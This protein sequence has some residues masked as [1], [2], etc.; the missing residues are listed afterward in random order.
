VNWLFPPFSAPQNSLERR[1]LNYAALFLTFFALILTLSPA[2]RLH[3]WQVDYRWVHWIG[4]AAWITSFSLA[5]RAV[6]RWSEEHD[7]YVLPLCGLLTGWGL[8]TIFRLDTMLGYRQTLWLVAGML[9]LIFAIHRSHWLGW[10]RRY[11][12][13]WLTTGLLLTA[14]T[15][16]FGTHPVG[17]GPRLWLGCCG[18]FFQPSEP[19]KVLLIL[20][21]AAYLADRIPLQF[22][23][24]AL[25]A[26]TLVMTGVAALLLIVQRDLGA[27]SLIIAIYTLVIFLASGRRR[28]LLFSSIFLAISAVVGLLVFDVIRL[29]VEAWLNPWNDTA[30]RSFQIVQSLISF[31]AG[32]L[33]GSGPGL[34]SPGLVPVAHSDFIAAAIS[35]E[36]GLAGMVGLLAVIALL[37]FR[38]L[39]IALRAR[40]SFYRFLAAGI[41][42]YIAVQSILIIGGNIRL[43]PLTGVTLPFVSYGG[44]S[45]A[46][47]LIAILFILW[48]S[49]SNGSLPLPVVRPLPYVWVASLFLAGF[50]SLAL[51]SGWWA[52]V[53]ADDLLARPD[54]VRWMVNARFVPR[55]DL[56]DRRNQVIATTVGSRGDLQRQ[57]LYPPLGNTVG[58]VNPR[59]GRAGLEASF[60][61]HLS[62]LR[63]NPASTIWLA[64]WIY[65]Q[66]PTGLR[67]RL[68][69]DIEQQRN[70]D[71]LLE[72]RTG[73]AVLLN[74]NTGEVLIMASHPYFDP[75]QLEQRYEEWLADPSAPLVNRATQGQYP[76][77]NSLGPFLYT[78]AKTRDG[79]PLFPARLSYTIND[80]IFSCA[81]PPR[82]PLTWET[83]IEAGCPAPLVELGRVIGAVQMR[84]LFRNL[85]FYSAPDANLPVSPPA[86]DEPIVSTRLA[87]LGHGGLRVSPLQMALAAAALT[88][89][90][91]RPAPRLAI[92]V[93]TPNQGWIILPAQPAMQ[94]LPAEE[95]NQAVSS[96][97]SADIPV[98]ET[99]AA[100]TEGQ[101][102]VSWYVAGTLPN[103]GGTPLALAVLIEEDNAQ[104]VQAIGRTIL[105]NALQPVNP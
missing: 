11:K 99:V 48:I 37:T 45:L 3:S 38:C 64:E 75:N 8:L 18:F 25:L 91:I 59:F 105:R 92:S 98:W 49:G 4:W 71:Q 81:R 72:G 60:D 95:T 63:A 82:T 9:V 10:L 35:E 86:L 23:L 14:L 2:V 87:S 84:D 15:F 65:S 102:S 31:A 97:S 29:R 12:Y 104:Q 57:L 5:Y 54:N 100:H 94:A 7:P 6:N 62:G 69:L 67:V 101:S 42:V 24:A 13:L 1:L 52:I 55:G 20:F 77:A 96:L 58:Y 61:G 88:N 85:G 36:T 26:P 90:G 47:S 43:L 79:L 78:Y 21:L 39:I 17:E 46:T 68:S 40:N 19:L 53:R 32:R 73:A 83:I 56:I 89:N 30:N 93:E 70:A 74:A 33:M 80:Q 22:N 41:G 51:L 76:P 27:A 103:W 16:I 44:S 66:S 34:G 50:A 28:I